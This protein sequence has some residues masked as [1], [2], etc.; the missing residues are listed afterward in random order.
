MKGG[1]DRFGRVRYSRSQ[2]KA[3]RRRR[4]A[5]AEPLLRAVGTVNTVKPSQHSKA[6]TFPPKASLGRGK[7]KQELKVYNGLLHMNT[8]PTPLPRHRS[9]ARR[10]DTQTLQVAQGCEGLRGAARGC[11][12]GCE[13]LRGAYI[14]ELAD[15]PDFPDSTLG[16]PRMQP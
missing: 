13:G 3:R 10:S 14:K 16:N 7:R 15:Q 5:G 12:D 1:R 4:V 11:E 9:T 2:A 6:H 8:A